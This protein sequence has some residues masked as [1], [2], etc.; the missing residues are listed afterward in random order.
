MAMKVEGQSGGDDALL[1]LLVGMLA[2]AGFLFLSQNEHAIT[3]PVFSRICS[4]IL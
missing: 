3:D 1:V 4:S 2:P